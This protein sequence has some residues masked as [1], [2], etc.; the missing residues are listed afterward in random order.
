M[1][2]SKIDENF[3]VQKEIAADGKRTY[4]LPS[5]YFSLHGIA[6]DEREQRFTRMPLDVAKSVSE[7]V[8]ALA[9][10]TAGGRARFST[11]SKTLEIAVRYGG[12]GLMPHMPLTGS[13]GFSLFEDTKDGEKFV[14]KLT[15]MPDDTKGF[16]GAL[17]LAGGEMREYVLYFPLYNDVTS[18]AVTLEE[19]ATVRK[20]KPY[21]DILP[22]LYYGSSIT[23]GG[24]A[25]RPDNAYQALICK[26]NRIDFINLGFSGN[27]KGEK[28][29]AEYLSNVDCSLFVCDYDY[30]APSVEHLERTH[31]ALYERF[32]LSHPD[33]PILFISKPDYRSGDEERMNIIRN[34]YRRA[35]KAGDRNVYF[36][37]G[38]RFFERGDVCDFT[39]DGCHPTDYGFAMM[40]KRIYAKM[41]E[42]DGTF[43]G[44][45]RQ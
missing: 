5:E 16:T 33:T 2:I 45:K 43:Q 7:G 8:F 6:Y 37:A 27:A 14:G 18:L 42:I 19:S 35:R 34:T 40:A 3:K 28:E 21:R 20:G 13:S 9:K 41:G 1:D 26:K 10:C 11:N 29:M 22:I 39:V 4:T 30:N 12:L 17:A 24:C 23:Q 15:P 31:Y 32:R 38:K 36:L 25:S 44:D